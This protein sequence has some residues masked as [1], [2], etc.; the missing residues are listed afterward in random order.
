AVCAWIQIPFTVPFTLQTMGVCIAAGLLG[1]ERGTFSVLVY[2]LIGLIGVPVFSGFQSGPGVLFG[3][4]GGYIIGFIFTAITV[5]L[6][7][8]FLGKKGW[9]YFVSMVLGIAVCYAFG[10][11]WYMFGYSRGNGAVTLAGALSMCVVPF[12]IPDLVK[13][14]FAA[15]ICTKLNK[16][17]KL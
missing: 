4:T 12:I 11:A 13:I 1:A 3:I 9:V 6:F 2:I 8:K 7:V 5:G 16:R 10:T 14:A 17:I 15:F